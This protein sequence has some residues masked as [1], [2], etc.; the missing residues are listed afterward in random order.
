MRPNYR[1]HLPHGAR[2]NSY[3]TGCRTQDQ[4]A[5][6]PALSGPAIRS[7]GTESM[8]LSYDLESGGLLRHT[9]WTMSLDILPSHFVRSRMRRNRP[10]TISDQRICVA[11]Y[12]ICLDSG[13]PEDEVRSLACD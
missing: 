8:S 6:L 5:T 9:H 3:L 4:Q 1:A 11:Q 12:L 10:K 13:R 2:K 7:Q